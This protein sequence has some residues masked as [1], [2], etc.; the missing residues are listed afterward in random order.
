MLPR[1]IPITLFEA[2]DRAGGWA[3][4]KK[5]KVGDGVVHFESGPRTLRASSLAGKLV[6]DMVRRLGLQDQVIRVPRTAPSAK[7]R[8]IYYGHSLN[9][10]PSSLM[11]LVSSI[12][13]PFLQGTVGSVLTEPFRQRRTQEMEDESV[14]SFIARRLNRR[15]ADNL[16]SAVFHGIY[17]GDIDKLSVKSTMRALWD[18][19][20]RYGS[21]FRGVISGPHDLNPA[22]AKIQE[23]LNHE[24][25][26]MFEFFKDASV[27]SFQGGIQT[28]V[29]AILLDLDKR[30]SFHYQTKASVDAI[31]MQDEQI[32]VSS[33]SVETGHS[34]VVSTLF[35]PATNAILPMEHQCEQLAGVEAVTVMVVNLFFKDP[36]LLKVRGF[37]YLVPKSVP[38]NEN[39]ERA[40]GVIFDSDGVPGQDTAQ[41]TKL[42]VMMGG[43]WW[44]G[45]NSIPTPEQGVHMA[46]AVLRRQLDIHEQPICTNA[47]LQRNCIPQY[48]IGH[49][50]RMRSAHTHLRERFDGR[51][52]VTGPSYRGVGFND[53]VKSAKE[54]A[55]SLVA[56]AP[57][58]GLETFLD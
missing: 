25:K 44:T 14:G 16:V 3:R 20:S 10:L 22:D 32:I 57:T 38:V 46:Q 36:A 30:P 26:E 43:H 31:R 27:Y 1:N 6:V 56:G 12:R 41:G 54:V 29:D 8:Y 58:T 28:L 45:S 19:E 4:T 11:S 17:A 55:M 51:L 2:S 23:E 47:T 52:A 21:L 53:C 39:P 40:L 35:A 33:N 15:L 48:Y 24:N 42:T 37:G 5:V 18:N 50:Q 49:H 9:R 7:N 13:D 34:H